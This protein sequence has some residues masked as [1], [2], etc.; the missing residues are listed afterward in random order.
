MMQN[1]RTEHTI[2][3]RVGDEFNHSFQIIAGKRAAIGAMPALTE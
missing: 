2:G 3:F 1:M